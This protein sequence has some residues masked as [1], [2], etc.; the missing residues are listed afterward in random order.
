ME[1]DLVERQRRH[2]D[3]IAAHYA[4]SRRHPNHLLLK[5]LIWSSFFAGKDFIPRECERVLEPMCG[6][7]EGHD[8]LRRHL[9]RRDFSYLGFDYSLPMV[10]AARACRPELD[11]EHQDVSTFAAD[12]DSWDLVVLIGGLHHVYARCEAVIEGLSAALRPGGYF[13]N[14]EPTHACWLTR[15]VR[16]R[17]YARNA[18][19]DPATE[20]GFELDDLDGL[21]RRQGYRKVDQVYAGLAAYVLYYNPDAFPGLNLG[22]ERAVRTAFWFDRLIWRRALGRKLAFATITLWQKA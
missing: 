5:D 13:L 21:F 9:Y 18:L 17:I 8:I 2:F 11:F 15:S 22:G 10:E 3:G 12:G 14:F 4:N 16:D 20:Q 19:F 1:E 6:L 7:G